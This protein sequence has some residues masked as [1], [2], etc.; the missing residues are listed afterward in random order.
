M[1]ET[2]TNPDFFKLGQ[3]IGKFDGISHGVPPRESWVAAQPREYTARRSFA[4]SCA[5]VSSLLGVEDKEV[6][7][8]LLEPSIVEQLPFVE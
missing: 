8:P 4:I 5:N 2:V 1:A 3:T 7:M 6:E